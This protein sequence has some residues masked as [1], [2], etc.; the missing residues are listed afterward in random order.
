MN[1]INPSDLAA[2]ILARDE[3]VTLKSSGERYSEAVIQLCDMWLGEV[4]TLED[5]QKLAVECHEAT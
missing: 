3:E 5:R 1:T 2:V 4:P